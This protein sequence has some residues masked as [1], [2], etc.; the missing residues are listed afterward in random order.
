MELEEVASNPAIG[1]LIVAAI[2]AAILCLFGYFIKKRNTILEPERN[3]KPIYTENCGARFGG[4]NLTIPF[5]R[6]A[7]YDDFL[8]LSCLKPVLMKFDEID[9]VELKRQ[10][11]FKG[12]FLRHHN[13]E[14]P[15]KVVI[16]SRNGEKARSIIESRLR[17]PV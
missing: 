13:K 4:L 9:R 16:W 2:F 3:L 14:I 12:I 15:S 1:M 6:L 17:G 7:I 8:V 10:L 5:V 11:F